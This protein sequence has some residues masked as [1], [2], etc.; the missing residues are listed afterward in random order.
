MVNFHCRN[1]VRM[2]NWV[3][4]NKKQSCFSMSRTVFYLYSF[5]RLGFIGNHPFFTRSFCSNN[6]LIVQKEEKEKTP[7]KDDINKSVMITEPITPNI[8]NKR[9]IHQHRVPQ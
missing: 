1:I 7:S 3:D 4:I 6:S 9:K 5:L 2:S 8:P